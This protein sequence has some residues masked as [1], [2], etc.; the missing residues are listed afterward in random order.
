MLE[1]AT[2]KTILILAL[3]LA[4]VFALLAMVLQEDV[5]EKLG[6]AFY[7]IG[8]AIIGCV[9]LVLAGYIWDRALM[10]SLKTLRE[11]A[12]GTPA[13]E[14]GPE[15][16]EHDEII[17]LARK[18]EQMARS[19]Q[20]V[21]ASYRAVVE[22]QVDLICRYRADGKLT[23]VNGAYARAL[24]RKR[25]D[26]I[27]QPFAFLDAGRISADENLTYAHTFR[28]PDGVS[29]CHVWTQRAIKDPHG[30]TLEYQAVGHDITLRKEAE[31]ALLRAKEAAEAADRAKSEFFA[32]ISHEIRT[33]ING[34]IGFAE[35]L[36]TSDLTTEQREQVELIRTSG[37]ALGTLIADILDF[38]KIEA[39][40]V[41]IEHAPFALRQCVE[42]L[43]AFFTPQARAAA[44]RLETVIDPAVPE[45]V[46]GDEAR[47]RQILTNLISNAVKFTERGTVSITLACSK[48]APVDGG[49]SPIRLFFTVADT[50]VGMPAATLDRLF[51][52]F[53]QVD[54][55]PQRRRNGTG[56]G[57]AISNRLCE[58]MGG[59]ISVESRPGEGSTFRFTVQA[60]YEP[61]GPAPLTGRT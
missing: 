18:I 46:H 13:A 60:D 52:P 20:K 34:V 36:T 42:D 40:R 31:A 15:D 54:L 50:G 44:I 21:E 12:Q 35:M 7:V 59:S 19:L 29:V 9:L 55:S 43:A 49:L 39:G 27:G 23:F 6:P 28:L 10:K 56:L 53:S 14:S 24:G 32:V 61:D 38:S 1:S 47:L 11:S 33:P 22:D 48:S 45:I 37:Q 16:T 3:T 41:E 25:S 51:L 8:F 58:L 17:G 2:R 5:R 4:L 57:L 26:L 30:T